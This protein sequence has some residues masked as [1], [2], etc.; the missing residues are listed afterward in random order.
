MQQLSPGM[1]H[2][3][4]SEMQTVLLK[5]HHLAQ[6]LVTLKC[7]SPLWVVFET[8][9]LKINW[10]KNYENKLKFISFKKKSMSQKLMWAKTYLNINVL[11]LPQIS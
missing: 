9:D 3:L 2:L 6:D 4:M 10:N 1:I 11:S 7:L 8:E 5:F